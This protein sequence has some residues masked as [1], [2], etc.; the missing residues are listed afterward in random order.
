MNLPIEKQ[1]VLI[2]G[3]GRGLGSEIAKFGLEWNI[4]V[5]LNEEEVIQINKQVADAVAAMG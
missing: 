2:T 4:T 3:A 1:T 5:V